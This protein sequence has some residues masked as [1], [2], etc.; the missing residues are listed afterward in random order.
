MTISLFWIS[1]ITII[2]WRGR[3]T[4]K[5]LTIKNFNLEVYNFHYKHLK[6][7]LIH[8]LNLCSLTEEAENF[9]KILKTALWKKKWHSTIICLMPTSDSLPFQCLYYNL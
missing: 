7:K 1:A 4:R 6:K 8:H 5:A 9:K 3:K 2:V